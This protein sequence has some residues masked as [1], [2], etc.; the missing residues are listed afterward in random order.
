MQKCKSALVVA[1]RPCL[2]L[3]KYVF[4]NN[5]LGLLSV[6]MVGEEFPAPL[7]FSR[8]KGYAKKL[9]GFFFFIFFFPTE[10]VL[11]FTKL[12]QRDLLL[13]TGTEG[14][15]GDCLQKMRQGVPTA[16]CRNLA[17]RRRGGVCFLAT[18]GVTLGAS[19]H[20]FLPVPAVSGLCASK[21]VLQSWSWLS[22]Y[23]QLISQ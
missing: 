23:I 16:E 6:N 4:R 10:L 8:N 2:F 7:C 19:L 12:V 18:G 3:F 21:E 17:I 13:A 1:G 22:Q 9:W 5:S 20:L 11:S 14:W 15:P